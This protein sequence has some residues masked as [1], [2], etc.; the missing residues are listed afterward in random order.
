MAL[1]MGTLDVLI[2]L[3]F[4]VYAIAS[5]F[6]AKDQASQDLEEYFLAGRSLPGWKAGLSMAA[7]QFAA[8]TPLVVMGTV[9]IVGIFGLWQLWIYALAFLLMGYLLAPSWRRVSVITDAELTEIRYGHRPAA[10][11]RGVKAIYFGTLFNCVVLAMVLFAASTI[12][13]P[14]L[15]WHLWLPSAIHHPFVSFVDWVGVSFASGLPSE[16]DSLVLSANN[17]ISVLLIVAV[18]TLYSTTGGLRSVV[19]TDVAQLFLM[20]LGTVAYSAWAVHEAGGFAE[21]HAQIA[22]IY[23]GVRSNLTV[24]QLTAFEPSQAKDA[25]FAVLAAFGLQWLLQL[26]ADG[27][28]YLAQRS[29]ACKSDEDAKKAAVWFTITQVLLRSLLW[30]PIAIALLVIYPPDFAVDPE[31]FKRLREASYV[32]GMSEL[33]P[34]GI[35][36][37]MLTGMLAALASTV[38]THLN[39]GS[40]YWTNDIYKR[41]ICQ[42]WLKRE[43]AGRELVWVA[44]GSNIL[45]LI[46]GLSIMTQLTSIR[47]T[48]LASLLLGAGIGPVLVLRWLW[49][50]INAWGEIASIVASLVTLPAVL[51]LFDDGQFALR[52]LSMATVATLAAVAAS[53]LIGPEDQ[54][55]LVEFYRRARPPGFWGIVAREAGHDADADVKRLKRGLAA[56][57]VTAGS[58]F[59]ALIAIGSLLSN[60]PAPTWLPS[61]PIWVGLLLAASLALAYLSW[62]FGF[63]SDD[64]AALS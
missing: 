40:S 63:R 26:N 64:T 5:G 51:Y 24:D 56:M 41:F 53:L 30:L 50:R 33:L 28:G 43:P 12:A 49:W 7:T 35:K 48:W 32:R 46:L 31:A 15:R 44:R 59:C 62:R 9:A 8:D 52:L 55:I 60:S 16:V 38:D 34:P 29:M 45:I 36:G 6:R 23:D 39:W 54:T 4:V 57:F 21:M 20:G 17:L 3:A 2:I 14:F 47:D 58:I 1:P 42:S 37:L 27:T 11:L 19:Q 22:V 25:S 10:A 18:T 61:G 13:E